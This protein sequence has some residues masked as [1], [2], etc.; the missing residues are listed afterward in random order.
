MVVLCLSYDCID[1]DQSNLN[2]II[3]QDY[4]GFIVPLKK[5]KNFLLSF[6]VVF[7]KKKFWLSFT[8]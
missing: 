8:L 2:K 5:P 6:R 1:Q 3:V 7:L 4:L